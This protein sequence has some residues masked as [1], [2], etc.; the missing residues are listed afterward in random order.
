MPSIVTRASI[1]FHSLKGAIWMPERL[2][3]RTTAGLV[4]PNFLSFE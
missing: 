2:V 3:I 4:E 1:H